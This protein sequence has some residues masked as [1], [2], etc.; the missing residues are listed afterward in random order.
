MT[1][2]QLT[3]VDTT[4][5]LLGFA[6]VALAAGMSEGRAMAWAGIEPAVELFGLIPQRMYTGD[7]RFRSWGAGSL[8][9]AF[10]PTL[11]KS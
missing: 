9:M 4:T 5:P 11:Y 6:G 8:A 10:L 3:G 7:V 2:T 1:E